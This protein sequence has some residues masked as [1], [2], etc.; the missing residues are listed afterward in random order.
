MQRAFPAASIARQNIFLAGSSVSRS[1]EDR[2]PAPFRA[3]ETAVTRRAGDGLAPALNPDEALSVFDAVDAL[4]IN[5]ARALGQ[6]ARVGSIEVGKKADFIVI[7]R[8]IFDLAANGSS[9]A[10]SDATVVETWFDGRPV[11]QKPD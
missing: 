6:S 1:G 2:R 7:D 9:G 4:T 10:I 5:A 8:D 3:I 11:Y